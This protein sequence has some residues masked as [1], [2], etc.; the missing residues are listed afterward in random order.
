MASRNSPRQPMM[1]AATRPS[2]ELLAIAVGYEKLKIGEGGRFVIPAA[3]REA[4]RV[5]PGDDL[6]LLRS[7]T[8][9][10]G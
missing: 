5:K 3:M 8:A 10:S 6:I 2:R 4:M 1:H 7:R 9:N